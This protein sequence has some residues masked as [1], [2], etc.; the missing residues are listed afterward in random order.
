M[1]V[2][3]TE[4]LLSQSSLAQSLHSVLCRYGFPS[5]GAGIYIGVFYLMC[6]LQ[7]GESHLTVRIN[8]WTEV[9]TLIKLNTHD[10]TEVSVW[11]FNIIPACIFVVVCTFL[12][13]LVFIQVK[14]PKAL[15][16]YV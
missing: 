10:T 6:S 12:C 3:F 2:Y 8:Q 11:K 16:R 14:Q 15:V 1:Y 4:G 7:A 9:S 13:V 5:L